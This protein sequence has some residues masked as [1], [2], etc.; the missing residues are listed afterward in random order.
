MPK[1]IHLQPH[2]APEELER[3][4]KTASSVSASRRYHVLWLVSQDQTISAAA[5]TVGYTFSWARQLVAAY[6]QDG[7]A[8]AE[9]RRTGPKPASESPVSVLNP[10]QKA[11]LREA[12]GG[13]APDG[14]LWTGP[15]VSA[16]ITAQTGRQVSPKLGWRYLKRLGFSFLRPRPKHIDTSAAEQ[17]AFKKKA[18]GGSGQSPRSWGAAPRDLGHG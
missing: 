3:R 7:P 14:G 10:A 6:N 17:E 2:L 1:R 16:W 15:K 4:Y 18:G 5:V 12:L 13:S 9:P 8:A 11:L